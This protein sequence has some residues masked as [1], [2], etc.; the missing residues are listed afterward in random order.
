MENGLFVNNLW[1]FHVLAWVPSKAESESPQSRYFIREV[2]PGSRNVSKQGGWDREEEKA[3]RQVCYWGYTMG[4][5]GLILSEPPEKCTYVS[6][7]GS[8]EGWKIVALST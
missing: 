2:V 1:K 7:D 6:Q 3:N 4:N 5:K 8:P